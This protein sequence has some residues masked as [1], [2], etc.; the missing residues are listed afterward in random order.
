MRR[1]VLVATAGV[2][3]CVPYGPGV[4][5]SVAGATL[6]VTAVGATAIY[7]R[8]T[9]GCW[10]NC[11]TGWQCDRDSGTCVPIPCGGCRADEKCVR[12]PRGDECVPRR[13]ETGAKVDAGVAPAEETDSGTDDGSRSE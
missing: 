8:Q 4:S 12:S 2:L 1:F 3:G 6:G 13:H 5:N 11:Q 9:G 7:R 10:A